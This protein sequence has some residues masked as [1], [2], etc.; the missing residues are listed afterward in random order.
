M[1]YLIRES[2]FPDKSNAINCD[3]TFGYEEGIKKDSSSY[4]KNLIKKGVFKRHKKTRHKK[5]NSKSEITDLEIDQLK[6]VKEIFSNHGTNY[7]IIISPMY[8]QVPLER[9]QVQLLNEIFG[10]ENIYNFSGKNRFTEPIS[11]YYESS[12]YRTHVADEIFKIIY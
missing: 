3:F 12:H 9:D 7:K 2:E 6:T 4:Y 11:N 5:T 8:D 10:E 1:G